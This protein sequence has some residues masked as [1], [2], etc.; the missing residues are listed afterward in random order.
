MLRALVLGA[1]QGLTEFIPISSSGHLVLVP[2]VLGWGDSVGQDV[3][4]DVAV[5]LG[6]L[7]AVLV[8]FRADLWSILRG[9]VRVAGG[10]GG[11]E[12]RTAARLAAMLAV[13]SIPAAVVGITLEGP[14]SEV[15]EHPPAVAGLLVGT[16]ALLLLGDRLHRRKPHG[17]RE[18]SEVGW[19][20]ALVIGALQALSILPGISRSGATIVAGI[21]RG[22]TREAAA[23]FSFLLGLPAIAGAAVVLLPDLHR[24]IPLAWVVW[25]ALVAAATGLAAI[26][27]L[28]RYLRTRPLF[29]FAY[30][31]LV[32]ASVGF[33]SWLVT[34]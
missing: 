10:R 30:Y 24:G 14:L 7:L 23:R 17:R 32:A 27:F 4:F 18:V 26:A 5:H 25:A 8:Y 21:A 6:T 12:D 3:A 22:L 15:F 29:P 33:G 11:D 34:R 16:A 9:L 31:C 2:F 13:G 19:S 28:L 1:V 20:D